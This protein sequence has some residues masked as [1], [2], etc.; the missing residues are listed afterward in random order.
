MVFWWKRTNS[1]ISNG[2]KT[3]Q[4]I[5]TRGSTTRKE[6]LKLKWKVT[7]QNQ[8]LQMMSLRWV[9]NLCLL[10]LLSH[11]IPT[12]MLDD[13]PVVTICSVISFF[14]VVWKC[15]R[16]WV[17]LL[18]AQVCS[19]L[20]KLTKSAAI[21][22]PLTVEPIKLDCVCQKGSRVKKTAFLSECSSGID[23]ALGSLL[24]CYQA[25]EMLGR[26]WTNSGPD[27]FLTTASIE[28]LI[29]ICVKQDHCPAWVKHPF[30]INAYF[31]LAFPSIERIDAFITCVI[32][33]LSS[34]WDSVLVHGGGG[35]EEGW[36]LLA[37][38]RSEWERGEK[39]SAGPAQ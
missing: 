14:F 27:F 31:G 11:R 19:P 33:S 1:Y 18:K 6:M 13:F 16:L 29:N 34:E 36:S 22:L 25:K 30:F 8:Q 7:T 4:E 3:D 9:L 20:T 32:W 37:S 26:Q 12:T 10:Y 23:F 38:G 39:K 21:T 24:S 35:E 2:H 17:S 5:Q 15:R 28:F